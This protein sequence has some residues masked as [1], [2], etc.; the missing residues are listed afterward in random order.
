MKAD[1]FHGDKS[2]WCSMCQGCYLGLDEGCRPR[3]GM[4]QVEF[5]LRADPELGAG[6]KIPARTQGRARRDQW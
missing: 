3:A 2:G 5:L 1:F 4:A 6:A